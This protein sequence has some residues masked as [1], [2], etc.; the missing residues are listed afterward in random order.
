MISFVCHVHVHLCWHLTCWYVVPDLFSRI[1]KISQLLVL[2]L[3]E[4]LHYCWDPAQ[5]NHLSTCVS[6]SWVL[7][8][9]DGPPLVFQWI[10][11]SES[12]PSVDSDD[13]DILYFVLYFIVTCFSVFLIIIIVFLCLSGRICIYIYYMVY[14]LQVIFRSIINHIKTAVPASWTRKSSFDHR[15]WLFSSPWLWWILFARSG[16]P[17]SR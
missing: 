12:D 16:G 3:R 7:V 10:T 2:V 11:M 1:S 17:I 15:D 13:A 8:S 14:K 9:S 6:H 5:R 4:T